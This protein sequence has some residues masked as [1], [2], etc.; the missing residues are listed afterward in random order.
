M[1][2]ETETSALVSAS[3]RSAGRGAGLESQIKTEEKASLSAWAASPVKWAHQCS[4][5]RVAMGTTCKGP[6]TVQA[7]PRPHAPTGM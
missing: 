7:R 3:G 2:H 5:V 4:L 1:S 6:S